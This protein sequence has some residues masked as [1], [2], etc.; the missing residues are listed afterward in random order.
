MQ[1]PENQDRDAPHAAHPTGPGRILGA[2]NLLVDG[3]GALG[4][5]LI[6][7]LMTIICADVL[8]RNTYGAS[9]PMVAEA[10]ALTL[11]MIVYLQLA[12]TI[13]HDR[14]SRADLFYGGFCRRHPRPGALLAAVHHL[15]AVGMLGIIAWSTVT[16][17]Q[18]DFTRGEH[19]GVTGIAT[20]PTWPFRALI[21]LGMAL[22]T[23]QCAVQLAAALRAAAGTG[24]PRP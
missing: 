21:L 5:L 17:V 9:L 6:V 10:G 14:L 22:A 13:R 18:R 3:L 15:V 19:I 1:A 7:V 24:G 4:T 8:V 11:V 20:L 12:T 16:I 2:W 23:V